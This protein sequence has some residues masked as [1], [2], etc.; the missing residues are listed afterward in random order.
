MTTPSTSRPAVAFIP[1]SC[2]GA[3][4]FRRLRRELGDRVTFHALELP[5]HGRRYQETPLTDATEAVADLVAR[6]DAPLDAL[7]GESLGA[8]LALGVAD[9]LQQERPPLLL[10]ASNSP[11]SVRGRIRT[12]ELDTIEAAVAALR[13]MGGEIPPEVISDPE[14]A[15]SAYPLIRADLF[16]SQ[17][18][19]DL[20]RGSA[21]AGNLTVLA[22]TGDTALT[23]LEAWSTHT[24]GHCEVASLSGGHLLSATNPAAVAEHVLEALA[25]G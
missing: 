9:V 12:E 18:C 8:Y 19:I 11:P 6:I 3:G 7:Y 16:L 1:P 4:Y 25:R 24:R 15:E 21:A 14:L 5:G 10:A 2:C 23:R 22:G 17:S 13:A 20:V